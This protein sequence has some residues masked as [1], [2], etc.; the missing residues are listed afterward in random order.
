MFLFSFSYL[1]D[2]PTLL[3]SHFILLNQQIGKWRKSGLLPVSDLKGARQGQATTRTGKGQS[4]WARARLACLQ[5]P[6]TVRLP[7]LPKQSA[8]SAA[9]PQYIL[10]ANSFKKKLNLQAK[11][12]K[13]GFAYPRGGIMGGLLFLQK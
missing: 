9:L 13:L 5:T 11:Q 12:M 4:V 3:V 10:K 2:S 6:W 1:W 8:I 7:Q